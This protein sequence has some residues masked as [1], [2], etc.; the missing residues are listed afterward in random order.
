MKKITQC[1]VLGS[2]PMIND[3]DSKQTWMWIVLLILLLLSFFA[4]GFA[5]MAIRQSQALRGQLFYLSR[6]LGFLGNEVHT[7]ANSGGLNGADGADGSNGNGWISGTGPPSSSVGNINDYYLD[8][9]NGNIYRKIDSTT[10]VFIGNIRGPSGQQGVPGDD[11]TEWDSGEGPPPANSGNVGDFYL[12][13]STGDVYEKTGPATWTIVANIRGPAG[14]D[15]DDGADGQ[16]GDDGNG[17]SF[18]AGAPAANVGSDGDLY[19]DTATFDVYGKV[20][21]SWVL[22]G[23]I[24]GA[25]GQDGADG[26]VEHFYSAQATQP[27]FDVILAGSSAS[28]R[29][30]DNILE[31]GITHTD[32]GSRI[33]ITVHKTATYMLDYQASAAVAVGLATVSGSHL[34]DI[35]DNQIVPGSSFNLSTV[36]SLGDALVRCRGAVQLTDTH[37]YEL[38]LTGNI[39]AGF[40]TGTTALAWLTIEEL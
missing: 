35:T 20:S 13:E 40:I 32:D 4:M 38:R 39:L 29:I 2:R 9:N 23:N 36:V 1:V 7:L 31:S 10:W 30:P 33:L 15:G 8:L 27:S 24:R 12:D 6:R 21:G 17:W 5:C 34:F 26:G 37:V 11:G 14:Q 28:I 3:D 16:D 19:L 18:A 25:D 22:I